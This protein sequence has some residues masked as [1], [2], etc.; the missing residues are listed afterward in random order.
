MLYSFNHIFIC[1]CLFYER[2][3]K[4][5][6]HSLPL[7]AWEFLLQE[8]PKAGWQDEQMESVTSQPLPIDQ[9]LINTQSPVLLRSPIFL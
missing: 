5:T 1:F 7:V 6:S 9:V 3:R 8:P 2:C 4:E